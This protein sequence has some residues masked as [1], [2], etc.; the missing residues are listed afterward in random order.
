VR[1]LPLGDS[2]NSNGPVLKEGETLPR[3]SAGRNIMTTVIGAGY[4]KTMQIPLV[5]GRDF[6]E[7]DQPKTQRVIIVNQRLAEMLWPGESAVGKRIFIGADSRDA[8]EVVGV[9]KTGKYRALAEDPKPFFY[10]AM[11]Q[12]RPTTMALVIR[13]KVDPSSLVGTVRSEIQ[14]LDRR[15]PVYGFKTMTEHKTYALWAPNM[16]ATFS[17][18]FGVI[19]VLRMWFRNARVR[20]AFAWRWVQ[21]AVTF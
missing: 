9:V 1:T 18:A 21:I 8:R 7:R 6:D 14:A 16:A 3:G 4:F 5:E 15:M 13:P 17:L 11:T 2:S 20:S 19:A 10:Y 12:L